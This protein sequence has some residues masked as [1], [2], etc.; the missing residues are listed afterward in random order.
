MPQR[1]FLPLGG[2][3]S[4]RENEV[5]GVLFLYHRPYTL[6]RLLHRSYKQLEAKMR[7][8]RIFASNGDYEMED[9]HNV[10]NP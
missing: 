3:L 6:T 9:V 7:R 8:S 10:W 5:A 1:R 2:R 4:R